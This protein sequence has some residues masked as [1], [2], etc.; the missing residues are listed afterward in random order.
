MT[1]SPFRTRTQLLIINLDCD[2][3]EVEEWKTKYPDAIHYV[4]EGK[5]EHGVKSVTKI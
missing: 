4:Y 5:D 3:K 1:L 2:D